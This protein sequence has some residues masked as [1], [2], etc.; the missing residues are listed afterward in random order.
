MARDLLEGVKMNKLNLN[1]HLSKLKSYTE[2]RQHENRT[3]KIRIVGGLLVTNEKKVTSGIS[4][5]AYKNGY[6]G[7]ASNPVVN[8]NTIDEVIELATNNAEFLA[9]KG[10][11]NLPNPKEEAQASYHDYSTKEKRLSQKQLI[12]FM[13]ELDRLVESLCPLLSS[14]AVTLSCTDMEKNLITSTGTTSYL[15]WPKT[16]IFIDMTINDSGEPCKLFQGFG[17]HGH[18]EDIFKSV[19]DF[20]KDIELLYQELLKKNEGVVPQAGN[21]DVILD[22]NLAG[23]L[24]HEAL[25]HTVEADYVRVGTVAKN[26]FGEKVASELI[27]IVDFAHSYNGDLLPCP[28]HIDDEGVEAKDAWIIKDGYLTSYLHNRD[29]SKYFSMD[30]TGN[31]RAWSFSD[32]PI[33]RMRNTCILPGTSKLEDM[34]ASIDKGYYFTQTINGEADFSGEFMFAV[35]SGYEIVNGKLGRAIKDTTISGKAFEVLSSVTM[36]SDEM[37]WAPSGLCGKKQ[38]IPVAMGGPAI[39]CKVNIGGQ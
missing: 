2:L 33:I 39:K 16:N 8:K 35:I 31:A 32:E 3:M 34:I 14:R 36:V 1:E 7:F 18:F 6:W 4:A 21:H 9:A 30:N 28:I 27:S 24:A 10:K 25:G 17:G 23:I 22:A 37:K 13:Y 12:E 38:N 15:N 11:M 20:K 26:C 29:S 19:D 5:R